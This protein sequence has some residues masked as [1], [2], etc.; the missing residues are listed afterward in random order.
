MREKIMREI[1]FRVWDNVV[2][3]YIDSRYV[4]IDGLGLL[5]VAK[6]AIK[7][8]FRLPN[9]RKSPW[10]TDD[11]IYFVKYQLSRFMLSTPGKM[12]ICLS[13]LVYDCDTNQLNCEIVDSIHEKP[14]LLE[15]W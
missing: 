13:E 15:W 7:D 6:R 8:C 4:S 1:K 3:K 2:K 5:H 12:S 14:E 11:L 9:T 10:F